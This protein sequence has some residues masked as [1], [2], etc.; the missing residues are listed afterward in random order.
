MRH[1]HYIWYRHNYMNE[2]GNFSDI[3][4]FNYKNISTKW[5]RQLIL[6]TECHYLLRYS[7]MWTTRRYV[8]EDGNI[9]NCCCENLKSYNSTCFWKILS[10]IIIVTHY[11]QVTAT[12]LVTSYVSTYSEYWKWISSQYLL[13]WHNCNIMCYNAQLLFHVQN[14]EERKTP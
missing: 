2:V 11:K 3:T 12:S 7:C 9:C 6:H 13:P 10:I 8:P 5:A 1:I 14:N 4:T